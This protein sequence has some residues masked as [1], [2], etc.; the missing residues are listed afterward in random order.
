MAPRAQGRAARP[1]AAREIV[2]LEPVESVEKLMI[3]IWGLPAIGILLATPR[4]RSIHGKTSSA[5]AFSLA[6]ANPANHLPGEY[7]GFR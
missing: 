3:S 6:S 4:L 7:A 2:R 5:I 1:L